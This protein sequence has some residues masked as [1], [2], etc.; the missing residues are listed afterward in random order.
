MPRKQRDADLTFF[1]DECIKSS[2]IV[3]A[4]DRLKTKRERVVSAK[5]ST[6]DEDWLRD[7]GRMMSRPNELHAI[8]HYS[9]ALFTLDDGT[10][11]AV[12]GGWQ[13]CPDVL[14]SPFAFPFVW[15]FARRVPGANR[16]TLL[17]QRTV[18]GVLPG[19]RD[20]CPS[21]HARC[22]LQRLLHCHQWRFV[23]SL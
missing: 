18:R 21:K 22:I 4:L 3:A 5:K 1:I 20:Q 8:T 15:M 19:T 6:L 14:A 16:S 2:L 7:A 13:T 11:G 10:G 23:L 9:V 12:G 17:R